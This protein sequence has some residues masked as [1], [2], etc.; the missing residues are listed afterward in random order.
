MFGSIYIGMSGL[1]AYSKGL[2]TV[3]NNVSNMNTQGFKASD[4]TFSN[5]YGVG[6]EGGLEFGNGQA[7]SGHGVSV[8]ELAT[9]FSQG[10][11]RQTGRDLDLAIDGNGFFVLMD[12]NEQLYA[13]TGSFAVD[14]DGFIVLQGTDFKLGI[15][16]DQGRPTA[17][18]IDASR[19]DA[20]EPTQTIKFADNLSS[21]AT[22]FSIPDLTVF[23]ANGEEHVWSIA[24]A[25]PETVADKWSVT[26]TNAEGNEI[27]VKSLE[28]ENGQIKAGSGELEFEDEDNDLKIT[29]DFSD[30]VTQ[31]SSGSV[32]S[33]RANDIDGHGT[34]S[35]ATLTV[36][37]KGQVEITYTNE[38][39]QELGA[40]ALADFRDPQALE[41]R[42]NS[43]F[44]YSGFGQRQFLSASDTRVGSILSQRLE[45]SNVDLGNQF[46]DLILIQRGFQASS[47]IISVTNDMIQQLFGIR[48]QG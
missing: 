42:G 32:S 28:F 14:D 30:G 19:T 47:Q 34:G 44:A 38:E 40:V 3:S 20:P 4:V 24:F 46:S 15:L 17:L 10:E 43:V 8:N 48:G 6:S 39:T 5:V 2:E 37:D 21:T 22:E 12:G 27:G 1:S 25:R 7:G 35:L 18:N 11:L 13:R 36:N 29:L 31:F 33:L 9:N 41:Q 23:G 16:D 26:V 45:A